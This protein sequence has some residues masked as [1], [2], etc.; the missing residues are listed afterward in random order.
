MIIRIANL[1]DGPLSINELRTTLEAG[2]SKD[3]TLEGKLS[4]A[5]MDGSS[6]LAD[7]I[8][9]G[10]ISLEVLDEVTKCYRSPLTV[11][12]PPGAITTFTHNLGVAVERQKVELI[13]NSGGAGGVFHKC[14]F[15]GDATAPLRSGI[16]VVRMDENSLDVYLG[17][18]DAGA[19]PPPIVPTTHCIVT[20]EVSGA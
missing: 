11:L 10:K 3:I 2:E 13:G 1:Y 4:F 9:D 7:L 20:I 6:E 16:C 17:A 14:G 8:S 19:G 15:W 12:N 18:N 5:G